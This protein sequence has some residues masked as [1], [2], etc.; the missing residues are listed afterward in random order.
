MCTRKELLSRF[1]EPINE[2]GR[3]PESRRAQ[4]ES[5][6]TMACPDGSPAMPAQA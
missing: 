2:D 6:T 5:F 3:L 1:Y 4:M